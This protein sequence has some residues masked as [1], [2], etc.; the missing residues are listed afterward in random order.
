MTRDNPGLS[1]VGRGPKVPEPPSPLDE[2]GT[3]LWN[4]IMGEYGIDDTA[5]LTVLL[6]ACQTM[7]RAASLAATIEREGET[8][9]SPTGQV[10]AHPCIRD[11]TQCRALVSRL[12]D[13][14]NLGP[15]E[16]KGPG[17]P[18]RPFGWMGTY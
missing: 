1:V 6:L 8:L 13:K 18:A 9:T 12:L 15:S 17:R 11:E 2:A 10:R 7:D 4:G 14:L 16:P 3:R 5:G